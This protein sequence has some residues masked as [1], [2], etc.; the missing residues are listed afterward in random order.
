MLNTHTLATMLERFGAIAVQIEKGLQLEMKDQIVWRLTYNWMPD[1]GKSFKEITPEYQPV[2]FG[3]V[4]VVNEHNW[5]KSSCPFTLSVDC[6]VGCL[7]ENGHN[8][9]V[10]NHDDKIVDRIVGSLS[11][12]KLAT[13]PT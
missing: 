2:L 13:T 1:D 12:K 10:E 7:L 6:N 5:Q 3:T 9:C 4:V 11:M 8:D